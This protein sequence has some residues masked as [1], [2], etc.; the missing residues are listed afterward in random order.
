MANTVIE[1]A[2][3]FDVM[4]STGTGAIFKDGQVPPH[5]WRIG[6]T[7]LL[8]IPSISFADL[9]TILPT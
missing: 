4:F 6:I 3:G 2:P 5:Y 9:G 8:G 1:I 7:V